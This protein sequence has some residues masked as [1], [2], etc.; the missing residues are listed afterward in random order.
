M[1]LNKI[2]FC[3][4]FKY[5]ANVE[6]KKCFQT[7]VYVD[8]GYKQNTIGHENHLQDRL[9]YCNYEK[10]S[11]VCENNTMVYLKCV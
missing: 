11:W 4:L 5:P 7:C 3:T 10:V 2:I 1:N 6:T 8:Y 9:K